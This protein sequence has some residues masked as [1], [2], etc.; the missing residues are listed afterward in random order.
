MKITKLIIKGFRCF[1]KEENEITFQNNLTALIG[2]NS[3]GKTTVLEALRKMFA[4]NK[5]ERN[6]TRQ[7]FYVA[8]DET[9]STITSS[10]LSIEAII[11]FEDDDNS[12]PHFFNS[13][14]IDNTGEKPYLRI[15]LIADWIAGVSPEGEISANLYYITV[16]NGV[17]ETDNDKKIVPLSNR[18]LIQVFYVPAIRKPSEQLKFVSGSILWRL[19]KRINWPENFEDDFKIKIDEINDKFKE[20]DGF[21]KLTKSISKNWKEFHRDT[22]YTNSGL[23]FSDSNFEEVLKRLETEFFPSDTGKPARIDDLGEGLRSLFYLNLVY[24][25]LTIENSYSDEEK[26]KFQTPELTILAVEEPENHIAPQILGKVVSKLVELSKNNNVQVAITSH[27]P[28]IIQRISPE[29][30]RHLRISD[31]LSTIV[32]QIKLPSKKDEAYKYTKEA[33]TNFPEIYFARLVVIGEGD[34]EE[35]LFN[36]LSKLYMKSFDDSIITF[37]PLGGRFV[38]HIWKLLDE[39]AIPYVTL[40]D[41]D[42]ER[43][44]GGWGRI[45]YV[46]KQLISVGFDKEELLKVDKGVL[47]QDELNEMHNWRNTDTDTMDGW[48]E[49]LKE[50]NVFFSSPLD[51]DFMLLQAFETEYKATIETGGPRIPDKIKKPSEFQ[52][53][54]DNGVKATL[55]SE[56]AKGETYTDIEREL[57]IYY[58][59]F[60]LGN[61]GKPT[62]HLL[63]LSKM[64]D[65]DLELSLPTVLSEMFSRISNMLKNDAFS[66]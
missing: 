46:C 20:V 25:L 31:N 45:K 7:D 14:V 28:S 64:D 48:I 11:E 17:T 5:S 60:F 38:N 61:R 13:F 39:L 62:T 47:S 43:D 8:K 40:L 36:R 66:K 27:T 22:R 50:Y 44:G 41:L 59:Y 24:T 57:M 18:S 37:V 35:V 34:S 23:T 1:N 63:A 30:I 3:S 52:E 29:D 53:K 32:S 10:N 19:L 16:A 42:R 33:I 26:A 9:P 65:I 58:N 15:R 56:K 54:I 2:L 12:I 55:K 6:L 4:G 21:S 51:L 49:M